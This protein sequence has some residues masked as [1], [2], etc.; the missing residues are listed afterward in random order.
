[1]ITIKLPYKTD[2]RAMMTIDTLRKEYSPI[3]RS[4]YKRLLDSDKQ[5]QVRNYLRNTFPGRD[6]WFMQSSI[7]EAMGMA[8][9]DRNQERKRVFGGKKNFHKRMKGQ[10]TKDEYKKL[11][12]SP[13]CSIG[14]APNKGNRKFSFDIKNKKITF[15]VDRNTHLSLELPVL[16][17]KRYLELLALEKAMKD[18]KLPVTIKLDSDYIYISYDKE[19][20]NKIS[21]L[22]NKNIYAAIDMNPNS[23]GF[24]IYR[25]NKLIYSKIYQLNQ[26]TV[27]SNKSS[28]HDKSKY[29]TNKLHHEIREISHEIISTC[30]Q[31]KVS[32][33]VYEDLNIK[34]QDHKKGRNFNRL[35]NNKWPW[36][37]FISHL[38][39]NLEYQ[40]IHVFAVNPAYSSFIGNLMN[41][42]LPDCLASASEIGRRGYSI[43]V[44]SHKTIYPAFNPCLFEGQW[45]DLITSKLIS[46]WKE[47]WSYAK[48]NPSVKYRVDIPSSY[49]FREFRCKASYVLESNSIAHNII[50]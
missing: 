9:V 1:M 35:V 47:L 17:K 32:L 29:L 41:Y 27:R 40:G 31:H 15:R 2:D 28:P 26:L 43:H 14:E 6:S 4:A 8:T 33:F 5:L 38:S 22:G 21:Y 20:L 48:N 45:K 44:L 18:K 50:L 13:I 10:I 25:K 24:V 19:K 16:H 12:L 37:K 49:V 7:Y 3:V 36:Q 11:R 42:R 46:S 30:I 23:I 34:N 39:R